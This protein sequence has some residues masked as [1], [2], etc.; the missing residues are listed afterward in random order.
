VRQLDVSSPLSHFEAFV[1]DAR[2]DPNIVGLVLAGSRGVGAYVT[3]ASDFDAYVIVGDA[4][5]V[6]EYATRFSSKHGDAIEYLVVSLDAFRRHA[7]PG[8]AE[9]WNAYTFARVKPLIDKLDGEV[10]RLLEQ[11]TIPG[12]GDAAVFLD[13]Y[14]NLLYRSLR[15]FAAGRAVEGHL[16]ASESVPWFL[17]FLFAAHLRVRPF[18]KWLRWELD[19]YPLEP[20]WAD[21]LE[22]VE[23][24]VST[25]DP[26]EQRRLFR[27]VERFARDRG[28]GDVIDGWDPDVP[29]MR[30]DPSA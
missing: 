20:A 12:D 10:T 25:G 17:D 8:T 6:D 24:I 30:D 21:V 18:N 27:D 11:K 2:E 5:L 29:F 16:D 26:D 23:A 19:N 7:L 15:N 14:L 22:R 13:G 28:L 4:T 9:R 3:P 1:R